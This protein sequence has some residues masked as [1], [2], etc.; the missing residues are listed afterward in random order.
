MNILQGTTP[1]LKVKISPTD[2]SVED[3]SILEFNIYHNGIQT[4]HGLSDVLTD[5]TDNSFTYRFTEAET[6][7]MNPKQPVRYQLRFVFADGSIVGTKEKSIT[8][9]MLRSRERLT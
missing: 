1:S 2:F 9:E 6:L 8:V 5:T 4:R 3:V 7:A